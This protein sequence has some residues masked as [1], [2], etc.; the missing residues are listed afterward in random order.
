MKKNKQELGMSVSKKLSFAFLTLL[1]G[2]VVIDAIGIFALVKILLE[3]DLADIRALDRPLIV[4]LAALLIF[5]IFIAILLRR[6]IVKSVDEPIKEISKATRLFSVGYLDTHI[7]YESGDEVGQLAAG[8]NSCFKQLKTMISEITDILSSMAE[9]NYAHTG[10]SNYQNDFQLVSDA[11]NRILTQQNQVMGVFV[12]SAAQVD[13]GAREVSNAAQQLAQGTTEQASSSEE[14]AASISDISQKISENSQHAA[15]ASKYLDETT[16]RVDE[17]DNQMRK[18]L[19]AMED[20]NQ[21]SDEISK[22]IKAIDDIAFQTNILA[23][24]AAVEA[25]RAGEA[26][27]GFAVVADEVRNLASKTAEE[28]KRTADLIETTI[29]KIRDGRELAM[30]TAKGL[31]GVAMNIARLDSTI[32]E[33][34]EAF[35]AQSEAVRQVT[36]GMEQISTV[37]QSNSATAEESAA[38]S[39]ELAGQA[40]VLK[41]ELSRFHLREKSVSA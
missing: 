8:L 20:I 36:Q 34:T 16:G 9:G 3:E 14:L 10:V 32:S 37:V 15:E 6:R 31:D 18:L 40:D 24:N 19:T 26:G 11:L 35:S 1:T 2:T 4:V 5:E 7:N 30:G 29:T 13:S 17:S 22:I 27:K 33:I 41:K 25:S 21:A 39:K 12:Q 38:A 23:L 28:S